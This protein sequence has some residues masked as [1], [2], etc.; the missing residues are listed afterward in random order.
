[1]KRS[2]KTG[3][4]LTCLIE[5]IRPSIGIAALRLLEAAE[6]EVEVPKQ[7]TCC[8]QVAWNSG[9]R[10]AAMRVAQVFL[11]AFDD[12]E[13][14]VAPSG[15]CAG[16]LRHGLL[17]LFV[18]GDAA[19]YQQ[20]R[21]IAA[22]SHELTSFLV[23]IRG[24]TCP[25]GR[26]TGRVAYHDSCSSLREMQVMSQPRL[27]LEATGAKVVDLKTADICCG[28]GG[29]FSV[30]Y[31]DISGA[32]AGEKVDDVIEQDPDLLVAGDLGCLLNIAGGLSRRKSNIAVRH[33]A[34]ILAGEMSLSPL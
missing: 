23:D 17:D 27:L 20:A 12:V 22:K 9:D 25:P 11:H 32:M 33:V 16:M 8:G 19:D 31:G 1:M 28:F 13:Y 21:R 29:T 26:F 14:V 24:M 30:K 15:S 34:E 7:Q 5:A 18:D 3:L 4:F 10:K 6:C 2:P